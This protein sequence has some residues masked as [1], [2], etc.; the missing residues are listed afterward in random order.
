MNDGRSIP[1]HQ[2][3]DDESV[4]PLASDAHAPGDGNTQKEDTT[5]ELVQLCLLPGLGP[6][7]LTSL[8]D[9]FGSA[10]SILN[11]DKSSLASV[12][13]VGPKMAHVIDTADDHVDI[14]DVFA[15]CA[16]KDVNILRRGQASYPAAL[17]ELDDAPPLIFCRGSILPRDTVSVAIVGTRHATAYGLQQTRRIAM[18]LARAGVT[19]VS[20]LA[21][22]IDT[23]AHRAALEAEG[24]TIAVLGGGLGKIYPAEN[25]PLA[26][27]ISQH[28]SVISE[29]APMAQPRGGMFPQRNRIIAALG[30]A[31]L[32]IEAPMRSGSL[33]TARLASELGRSVGSL[34]GQVNSRASQGCHHLIRDGATLV[35]HADDVL[36]LLGP[37][38]GNVS[39]ATATDGGEAVRDGREMTLNEVERQVLF[40]VGTSGTAIDEVTIRSGLPASRVNAI[41]SILEMKR[42]VRRLSGQ[43]VSRI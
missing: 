11:A 37:L 17:E 15:W 35:Q 4:V 30:Q 14:E 21:R 28:G 26:D 34:P 20:G 16:A 31:T 5:R 25:A 2:P 36:E 7:T 8:L 13:G 6:R 42:F 18:D 38:S 39:R 3:G 33:I 9:V 43:Y 12:H 22:G 40:A 23:A 29:Y 10:R 19:I 24:R 41:V 1:D 32:V 27:E